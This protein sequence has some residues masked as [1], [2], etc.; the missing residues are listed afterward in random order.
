MHDKLSVAALASL[1]AMLPDPHV[2]SAAERAERLVM[3]Q[4]LPPRA[5]P[6]A[7]VGRV[8]RKGGKRVPPQKLL[9]EARR[10]KKQGGSF[11]E[12]CL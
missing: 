1:V 3:G 5:A 11:G 9:Q 2:G 12:P 10:V 8:I 7:I 6:R 4:P